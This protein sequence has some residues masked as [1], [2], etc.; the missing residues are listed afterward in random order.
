MLPFSCQ[1]N[2]QVLIHSSFIYNKEQ[3]QY[4]IYFFVLFTLESICLVIKCSND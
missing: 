4:S 2:R 3:S 1:V